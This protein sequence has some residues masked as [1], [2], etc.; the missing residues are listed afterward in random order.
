MLHNLVLVLFPGQNLLNRSRRILRVPSVLGPA[1]DFLLD[2]CSN[3]PSGL[4]TRV[5]FVPVHEAV[6]FVER[7]V[8]ATGRV[9]A[10]ASYSHERVPSVDYETN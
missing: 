7:A 2:F 5:K 8:T 10:S 4:L 6:A 1:L 3:M 9:V